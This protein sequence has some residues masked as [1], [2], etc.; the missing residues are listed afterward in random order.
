VSRERKTASVLNVSRERLHNGELNKVRGGETRA[1][2]TK[3]KSK[4]KK[5]KLSSWNER[6]R[7]KGGKLT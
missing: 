4:K 1:V 3:S 6:V 5:R 7:V 2:R